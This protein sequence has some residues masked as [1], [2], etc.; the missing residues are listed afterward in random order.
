MKNVIMIL[1][2]IALFVALIITNH[3]HPDSDKFATGTF[4]ES[5][6]AVGCVL[7]CWVGIPVFWK[8][9]VDRGWG[10]CLVW[11]VLIYL[12][13]I[14]SLPAAIVKVLSKD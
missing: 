6:Y 12:G 7:T 9:G 4:L 8:F 11:I 1:L 2:I 14:F 13:L 10:C 3:F 5:F